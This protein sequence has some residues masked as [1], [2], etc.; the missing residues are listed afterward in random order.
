MGKKKP[1][2]VAEQIKI[3]GKQMNILKAEILEIKK[4][5]KDAHIMSLNA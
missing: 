2:T 5:L 1:P 3:L 4:V